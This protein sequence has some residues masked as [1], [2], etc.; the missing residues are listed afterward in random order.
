MIVP[1]CIFGK[2]HLLARQDTDFVGMLQPHPKIEELALQ[3]QGVGIFVKDKYP[4]SKFS[5]KPQGKKIR[6]RER[7]DFFVYFVRLDA[8]VVEV[9]TRTLKSLS[10]LLGLEVVLKR[11]VFL[12]AEELA[13]PF[14]A[15]AGNLCKNG[16]ILSGLLLF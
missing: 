11:N 7:S 5:Y 12:N 4:S 10:N 13:I 2:F 3:T 9:G 1:L 14:V 8:I 15:A 16:T 6:P